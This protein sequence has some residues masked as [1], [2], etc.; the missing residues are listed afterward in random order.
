MHLSLYLVVV[1]SLNGGSLFGDDAEI[2]QGCCG[3]RKEESSRGKLSI[4]CVP[5][6]V[7]LILDQ[8]REAFLFYAFLELV[9]RISFST[10]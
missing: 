10:S 3:S 8:F 1:N 4:F 6:L 2:S 7:M 9:W 5:Y